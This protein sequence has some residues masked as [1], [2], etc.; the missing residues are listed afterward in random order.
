MP[1]LLK[2]CG[3]IEV[4]PGPINIITKNVNIGYVNI[5]S[6]LAPTLKHNLTKFE[7]VK[8]HILQHDYDIF[9]MSETWLDHNDPE[10]NIFIDG[11]SKPIRRNNNH[12]QVGFLVYL[13]N[14]VPANHIDDLEPPNSE[15]IAIDH[16]FI[17]NNNIIS[18]VGVRPQIASD[19]EF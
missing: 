12:H 17:N 10:N 3:D 8:N 2:Q 13:S 14:S 5:W 15:I 7:M 1:N 19:H 18:E 6:I 11:Y 4:N 16:I 9:G